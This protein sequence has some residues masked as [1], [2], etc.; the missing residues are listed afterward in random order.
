MEEIKTA[1][2]ILAMIAMWIVIALGII[3]VDIF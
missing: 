3:G 2:L 1:A